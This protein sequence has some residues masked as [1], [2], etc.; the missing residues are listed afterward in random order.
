MCSVVSALGM[1]F[2]LDAIKKIV[3]RGV[4]CS[5]TLNKSTYTVRTKMCVLYKATHVFFS[6]IN[7]HPFSFLQTRF[8]KIPHVT[9]RI[10]LAGEKLQG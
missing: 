4:T 8:G 2:L 3:F 9:R 1:K 6:V 7:N 10:S 5:L